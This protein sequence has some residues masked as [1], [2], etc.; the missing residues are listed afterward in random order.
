MLQLLL[1]VDFMHKKR[2]VHRDIKLDNVLITCIEE[3]E[4]NVKIADFGLSC[5]LPKDVNFL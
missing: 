1:A 2:I 3:E 5:I 4:F